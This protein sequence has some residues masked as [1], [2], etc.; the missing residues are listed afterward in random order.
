[1]G[2]WNWPWRAGS[3]GF[4]S[5]STAEQVTEGIDADNLTA[6]VTG[7]TNGI[8]K[9][10]ARVLALRG[11]KVIIPSR[12]LESGTKVK[13]SLLEQNPS[14]KLQVLE[15]DLSSLHSVDSFARSFSSSN[16]HLNILINNAGIMACPFQLS[17][18]GIELQFATNHL[19]MEKRKTNNHRGYIEFYMVHFSTREATSTAA[20]RKNSLFSGHFLLTKL[21]LEKMKATAKA[22]GIQGRIVNVSSVAHK[23]SDGSCFDLDK[24]NDKSRYKPFGAY[25]HSKLANI[26]HANELSRRL[27]EEGA[28]V[29]ANSLHPGVIMTNIV[30]YLNLN[31]VIISL[32][33]MAKPFLKDIPEGAATNCY[34]ALH[35]KVTNV[36]GKYFV[37]CD[38][39]T[40]TSAARDAGLGKKLWDLSEGLIRT[41]R[42]TK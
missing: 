20:A 22:T 2:L 31:G 34:V 41:N 10:T 5:S 27:K 21:L 15:M 9:E 8:G 23:R 37:N 38:E 33:T 17:K 40:P 18:D 12:T 1:M 6:I 19:E 4:G 35:P 24:I 14:A 26:L 7:A 28:N 13:E 25:S 29:T 30:R 3:S 42:R 39:A 32:G 16:K 11:A 36:T